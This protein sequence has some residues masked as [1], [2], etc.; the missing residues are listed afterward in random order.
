MREIYSSKDIL[1]RYQMSVGKSIHS[2]TINRV[3]ERITG[4]KGVR[5][6]QREL[7]EEEATKVLKS[8]LKKAGVEVVD[9]FSISSAKMLGDDYKNIS[10]EV[11]RKQIFNLEMDDIEKQVASEMDKDLLEQVQF[12]LEE[13][14]RARY[15]QIKQSRQNKINNYK[16]LMSDFSSNVKELLR[17]IESY[18]IIIDDRRASINIEDDVALQIV[19]RLE[20]SVDSYFNKSTEEYFL[21]EFVSEIAFKLK[22]NKIYDFLK[23]QQKWEFDEEKL[24]SDIADIFEARLKGKPKLDLEEQINYYSNYIQQK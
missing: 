15:L 4:N 7:S 16:L 8:L 23:H 9:G 22:F 10:K 17:D 3:I 14:V 19:E 13:E 24:K 21:E 2:S 18:S 1:E 11:L 20:N 12:D 6:R 5:G